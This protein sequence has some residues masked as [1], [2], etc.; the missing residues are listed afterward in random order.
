M[1]NTEDAIHEVPV[2]EKEKLPKI[3]ISEIEIRDII[4]PKT[5]KVQKF[6][7][8]KIE[9]SQDSLFYISYRY[10]IPAQEIKKINKFSGEDIYFMKELMIPYE[11][12]NSLPIKCSKPPLDEEK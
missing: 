2:V 5:G 4:C 1:K 11:N 7:I 3:D 9:P 8:H 10:S 12:E 6:M